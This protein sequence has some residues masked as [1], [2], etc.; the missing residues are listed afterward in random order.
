MLLYGA[1]KYFSVED[2]ASDS[3]R[4]CAPNCSTSQSMDSSSSRFLLVSR[5]CF[6]NLFV[7]ALTSPTK[8]SRV[9]TPKML[10]LP[11]VQTVPSQATTS[12]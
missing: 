4:A 12:G 9:L 1:G 3:Q 8:I 7:A 10:I 2:M 5:H 6:L 11:I